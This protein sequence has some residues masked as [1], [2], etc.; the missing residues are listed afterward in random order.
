MTPKTQSAIRGGNSSARWDL[1]VTIVLT[2]AVLALAHYLD[3]AE[4]WFEWAEAHEAWEVDEIPFA[5]SIVAFGMV[6]FSVRRWYELRSQT[7]RTED[8]N[9][10]LRA[11]IE[12]RTEVEATS[13]AARLQAEASAEEARQASQVKSEFLANM[14]HEIR[15]P[16]NGVLGMAGLM[17]ESKLDDNQRENLETILK[18]GESLLTILNDILD[19]SKIEASKLEL[20]SADFDVVQ[21]LDSAVE[22]LAPQAHAKGLEIPTFVSTSVP[23]H[24]RGDDGRIRQILLNLISNAVKF[25]EDGGIS[26]EVSVRLERQSAGETVLRFEIADTGIGISEEARDGIFDAFAQADGSSVRRYGGTG[27]GLAICKRL[28]TLMDGEIGSE[29]REDGGSLFWFTV[30]LERCDGSLSWAHEVQEDI[31]N[32]KILVV[33]DNRI[34]RLVFEKQL[35]ALGADVTLAVSAETAMAKLQMSA[36]NGTPFDIAIIDHLMPGTD[37]LDL[38]AMIRQADWAGELRLVLSS[39]SGMINSDRKA[40]ELGFDSALPKPVRPGALVKCFRG[41][42]NSDGAAEEP[43]TETSY[44]ATEDRQKIRILVVEDNHINQKLVVAILKGQGYV[45]DT[46]TNG[47]EAIDALRNLPYDLVLM[48][49]QMPELDGVEATRRIRESA[50]R[51]SEIPII[52]VTARALRGDRE[53]VLQAGMNDYLSKPLDRT[54]LLT[55]VAFWTTPQAGEAEAANPRAGAGSETASDRAAVQGV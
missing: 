53:R 23:R 54:D 10:Q 36:E 15:T 13:E 38:G 40:Q 51:I 39:S 46:A 32:F 16:L 41:L 7:Q 2:V 3:I 8:A 27:L 48:D 47:L 21:M 1:L 45:T 4:M 52:G 5:L 49:V 18:S 22:L 26:I 12:R 11:E 25:T 35:D 42:S 19:F 17:L 9:R 6:W 43:S 28:V 20:E 34:N 24:L 55:K 50:G 33:D 31:R 14:S 44:V 30:S 29:T 37:G